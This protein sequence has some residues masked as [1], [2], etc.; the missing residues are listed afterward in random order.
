MSLND[1][2]RLL[3]DAGRD[4]PAFLLTDGAD[5]Y[6][7]TDPQPDRLAEV[8]PRIIRRAGGAWPRRC[9]ASC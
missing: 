1:A 7:L 6:L 5:Q 4:G 2:V 9:C 3:A 8:M